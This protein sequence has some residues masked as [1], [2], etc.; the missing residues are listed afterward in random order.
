MGNA[1]SNVLNNQFDRNFGGTTVGTA[2]PYLSGFHFIEFLALPKNL[3]KYVGGA[4][5]KKAV[6]NGLD[7]THL[8]TMLAGSCVGVTP[9]G[10]TLEKTEFTGL[11]GIKFS[12][13]T[14]INYSNSMTVKFL[15][16]SSLPILAIFSG[17]I[18]MIRDYKTGVSNL[19]GDDYT[20]S[21]YAGTMLYWTTKPDGK[22]VEFSSAYTGM[23]PL[24]DPMD[25]YTG[26]FTSQDKVEIDIEFN[27]DYIL[28]EDWVHDKAQGLADQRHNTG[29]DSKNKSHMVSEVPT[30]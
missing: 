30:A 1:F 17:W 29:V 16:F 23:F 26:E 25:M 19:K 21:N 12:V 27:V 3:S 24:K 5:G 28:H 7:S 22:T 4:D 18:R 6:S 8:Q 9:P 13:P 15:E 10:G 2:D 11:G 20:K 14:S